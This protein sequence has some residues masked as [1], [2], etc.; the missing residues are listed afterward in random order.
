M[1]TQ[2][3]TYWHLE[4]QGRIPS[5][6]DITSARLLCH[7]EHGFAV[8]TPLA[9]WHRSIWEKPTLRVSDWEAFKDPLETTYTKYVTR[10][11]ERESFVDGL[12]RSIEG[13]DHDRRLDGAWVELLAAVLPV[14]RFPCHG[15]QMLAAQVAQLAPTGRIAILGL[16]QAADELRRIQRFAYRMRQLVDR[17]PSFGAQSKQQWQT[18]AAWQPLRRTLERL[19]TT[20]DFGEAFVA[21]NLLLKPAFD[22]VF[23]RGLAEVAE[24]YADPL[25]GKLLFS[26][27]EDA[28]WH[29]RWAR[30][31]LEYALRSEATNR[32]AV[33]GWVEKWAPEVSASLA[34]SGK[35]VHAQGR[36]PQAMEQVLLELNSSD[37]MRKVNG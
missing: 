4:G 35:L 14:L 25:L 29:H 7:G 34:T 6:Y 33:A 16:F 37:F 23:L 9:R 18:T 13:T 11:A 3:R 21:L 5:E 27:G 32:T 17:D 30:A 15:L 12:F 26:L 24:T 31:L 22:G 2:R 10:Q 8:N 28:A 19:L 20:H 1:N 36:L